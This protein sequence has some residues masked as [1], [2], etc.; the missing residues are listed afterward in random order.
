[1]PG[2]PP[3]PEE[4]VRR[5]QKKKLARLSQVRRYVADICR[6]LEDDDDFSPD[7]ARAMVLA[8]KVLAELIDATRIEAALKR[9]EEETEFTLAPHIQK[10]KELPAVAT[11]VEVN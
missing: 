3:S 4:L 8:A 11:K 5:Q 10:H 2:K 7:R 9:F 6:R 1:M